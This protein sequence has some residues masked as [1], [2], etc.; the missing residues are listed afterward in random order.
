MHAQNYTDKHI[1][2]YLDLKEILHK[3]NIRMSHQRMLVL[4]YLASSK[5]HPT[6]E[7]VFKDLKKKDPVLSQATVYNTL[8]LFVKKN[9]IRELDFNEPSKRYDFDKEGLCH[10]ICESCHKI[11]DLDMDESFL[12]EDPKGFIVNQK[13]VVYRGICPECAKK[14]S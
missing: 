8:N 2:S 4:E 7:D 5:N 10:F 1:P 12:N 11:F 14:Q 9:I 13:Q 3:N 6:A